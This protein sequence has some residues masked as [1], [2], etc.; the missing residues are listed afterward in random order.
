MQQAQYL[1]VIKTGIVRF[2]NKFAARRLLHNVVSMKF[3]TT[4]NIVYR[5]RRPFLANF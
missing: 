2:E 5:R 1:T 4:Q 3:Y